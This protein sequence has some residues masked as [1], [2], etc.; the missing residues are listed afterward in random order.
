MILIAR[1]IGIAPGKNADAVAQAK[2]V[3]NYFSKNYG[4]ELQVSIPLGGNPQRLVWT[5]S[6]DNMAHMEEILGKMA[7]DAAFGELAMKGMDCYVAGSMNDTIL[8]T[9]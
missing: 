2:E 3:A 8:R 9:V 6:Y 1:S 4:V 7:A 5:G